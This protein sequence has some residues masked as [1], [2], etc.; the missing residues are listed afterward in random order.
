MHCSGTPGRMR[1]KISYTNFTC[2]Q[3]E[4]NTSVFAFK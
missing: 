2:L 3:L 4:K 1:L